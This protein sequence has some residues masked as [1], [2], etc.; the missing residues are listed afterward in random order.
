MCLLLNNMQEALAFRQAAV[1]H[2]DSSDDRFSLTS[3]R[4]MP[5]STAG[6]CHVHVAYDLIPLN[7][8]CSSKLAF[9][10]RLPRPSLYARHL[11]TAAWRAWYSGRTVSL[12]SC[13]RRSVV[14]GWNNLTVEV[15]THARGGL[16]ENDFI[17]AAKLDAVPKEDLV[18]K[19]KKLAES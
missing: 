1:M 15:W 12:S 5:A 19:A 17:L 11:P 13:L 9:V 6:S 8:P 3:L 4:V 18:R 10:P 7:M 14:Q 2:D 16:T